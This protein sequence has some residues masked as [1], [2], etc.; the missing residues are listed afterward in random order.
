M[1]WLN[2]KFNL[3]VFERHAYDNGQ[4]W[5]REASRT[6]L[7]S[8]VQFA[9]KWKFSHYMLLKESWVKSCKAQNMPGASQ[10]N[11]FATFS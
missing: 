6:I 2:I 11:G 4:T 10:L 7:H 5:I 3:N 8:A 1:S 9:K